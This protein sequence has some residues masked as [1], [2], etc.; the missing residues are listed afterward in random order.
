[1]A[2]FVPKILRRQKMAKQQ[3]FADKAKKVRKDLGVNVKVIKTVKTG[4]DTFKFSERYVRMDDVSK[5]TEI[6]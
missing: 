3:T 1:M 2:I 4:K 5:V 6:K